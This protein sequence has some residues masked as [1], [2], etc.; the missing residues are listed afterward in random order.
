[1]EDVFWL[2]LGAVLG[3]VGTLLLVT[4]VTWCSRSAHAPPA[5]PRPASR[6]AAQVRA[7]MK[8]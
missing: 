4:V 5:A 2:L 3:A 1:M 6:A 7:S 8:P